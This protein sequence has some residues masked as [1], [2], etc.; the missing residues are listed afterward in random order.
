MTG[1]A[2]D[3][4]ERDLRDLIADERPKRLAVV[5]GILTKPGRVLTAA[6]VAGKG[7][8]EATEREH[9]DVAVIVLGESSDYAVEVI[10]LRL[11]DEATGPRG[12][13]S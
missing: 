11:N 8:R 10:P 3:T 4:V 5:A 2:S 12:L 1:E 13:G 9:P 6:G 7:S